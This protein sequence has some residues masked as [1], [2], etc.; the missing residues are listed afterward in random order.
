MLTAFAGMLS[1]F[2]DFGLSADGVQR[3][4]FTQDEASQWMERSARCSSFA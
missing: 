1:L 4:T 3:T 2:P